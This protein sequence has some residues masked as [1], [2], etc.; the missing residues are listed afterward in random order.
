MDLKQWQG[1]SFPLV[2]ETPF[3]HVI[4]IIKQDIHVYI[5]M[6]PIAGQTAGANGLKFFVNTQG[7]PGVL[8][9]F[10]IFNFFL[11]KKIVFHGQRQA[12]QLV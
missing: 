6:F 2:N 12:L 5:Y 10:K 7:F 9:V 1:D 8:F 3:I 11:V 4:Y